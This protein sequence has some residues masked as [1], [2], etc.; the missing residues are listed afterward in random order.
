[1]VGFFLCKLLPDQTKFD[2]KPEKDPEAA[3]N[4]FKTDLNKGLNCIVYLCRPGTIYL[5]AII[6]P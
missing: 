5:R 2:V 6:L 1:M 3:S 4:S